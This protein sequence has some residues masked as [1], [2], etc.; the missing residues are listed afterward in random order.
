M[1]MA[2]ENPNHKVFSQSSIYSCVIC[3]QSLALC[4]TSHSPAGSF[5]LYVL[6]SNACLPSSSSPS[7]APSLYNPSSLILSIW[8]CLRKELV[9][10]KLPL[11]SLSLF[12]DVGSLFI[13]FLFDGLLKQPPIVLCCYPGALGR[14]LK[15]SQ[16]ISAD[17]T[18]A[19]QLKSCY[20]R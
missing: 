15:V 3:E 5:S 6:S 20:S 18:R 2:L 7:P 1:K 9:L 8:L 16:L 11:L 12:N 19:T 14:C 13:L 4:F 17:T 10:L